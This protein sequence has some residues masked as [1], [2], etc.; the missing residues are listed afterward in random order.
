MRLRNINRRADNFPKEAAAPIIAFPL[1][2]RHQ[3][4]GLALYGV[5]VT[6][7]D[8][9]PDEIR[10]ISNLTTQAAAAYDHLEAAMLRRQVDALTKRLAAVL[11]DEAHG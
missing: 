9:D 5:H 7:E 8:V 6:G 2:V 1:L 4:E 10:S 11:A 3:L